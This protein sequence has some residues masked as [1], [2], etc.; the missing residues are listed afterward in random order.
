MKK[1]ELIYNPYLEQ[2]KLKIDGEIYSGQSGRIKEFLIE[3]PMTYWLTRRVISYKYWNGLL[4]ELMDFLNDDELEIL[5]YGIFSDYQKVCEQVL[6]QHEQIE[7]KGFDP[8]LYH[9]NFC[10]HW[11]SEYIQKHLQDFLSNRI[12]F[13]PTQQS[14]MD[15]E[16]L[17]KE[18][19]DKSSSTTE[20]LKEIKKRLYKIVD[21]IIC[22]CENEKYQ[23]TWENARRE[24][25][26][27]F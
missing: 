7:E 9:L 25:D 27:I 14:M 15:L 23:K 19:H 13:A 3:K 2:A 10:E 16:F 20:E 21:E 22:K 11:N 4:P 12:V 6:K 1:I 5:F 26:H 17:S 18:L 8:N 24:L